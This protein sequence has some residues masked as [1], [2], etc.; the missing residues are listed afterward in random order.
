MARPEVPDTSALLD[1]IR[2]PERW[3]ALLR[4]MQSGQIW[5]SSVVLTELYVGSR[6][7]DDRLI[8]DRIAMVMRRIDRLLTPDDS[9]WIRAGRLISRRVRLH[10]TL[11][12]RDHLADVLILISAARLRGVVVT[13]NLRHFEAWERLAVAAGLDVMVR[14]SDATDEGRS[15]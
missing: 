7:A 8:L 4:S 6:S 14:S 1:A 12:P 9:D 11:R 15:P 13:A 10:G 5:L 3:P 2:R